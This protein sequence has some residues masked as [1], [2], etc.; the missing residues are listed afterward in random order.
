MSRSSLCQMTPL[1]GLVLA[2]AAGAFSQ[3]EYVLDQ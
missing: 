3:K 2:A 1:L